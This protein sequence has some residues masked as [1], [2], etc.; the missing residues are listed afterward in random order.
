MIILL[1]GV[2]VSVGGP[3]LVGVVGRD[4]G[5]FGQGFNASSTVDFASMTVAPLRL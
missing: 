2:G 4:M 3:L 1:T 5:R